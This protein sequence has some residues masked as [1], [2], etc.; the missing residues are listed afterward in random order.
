MYVY[1]DNDDIY[2]IFFSY[3]YIDSLW[4]IFKKDRKGGSYRNMIFLYDMTF[5]YK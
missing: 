5:R 3:L 2:F 1:N 4:F